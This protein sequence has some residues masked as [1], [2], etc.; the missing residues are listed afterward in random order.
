VFATETL[1][2]LQLPARALAEVRRVLVP[3]GKLVVS[4]PNRDWIRF[5]KYILRRERFQPIDDRFYRWRELVE[6]LTTSGF[7]VETVK[8]FGLGLPLLARI[9]RRL[10]HRFES[11]ALA[12]LP[13]L[14]RK[15]KRTIVVCTRV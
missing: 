10:A 6:L 12:F 5:N 9:S 11:I 4:V 14:N 13:A 7:R 8:G 15:C 1:E 3:G 2:H